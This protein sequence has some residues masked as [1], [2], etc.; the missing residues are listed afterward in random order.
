MVRGSTSVPVMEATLP[1][2]CTP[3]N[4]AG[5]PGG[6][7]CR[8]VERI[9]GWLLLFPAD[10][11]PV[12]DLRGALEERRAIVGQAGA[13]EGDLRAVEDHAHGVVLGHVLLLHVH[14]CLVAG[15]VVL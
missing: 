14:G 5:T 12:R 10:G 13:D 11:G 4:G 7:G 9:A 15:C 3:L 2:G 6:Q 8:L 1:R